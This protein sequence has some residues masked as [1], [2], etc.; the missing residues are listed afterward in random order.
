LS[1]RSGAADLAECYG[2]VLHAATGG[3]QLINGV[4]LG[5]IEPR[6]TTLEAIEASLF[7]QDLAG[8][9]ADPPSESRDQFMDEELYRRA[10]G[11]PRPRFAQDVDLV[12][13]VAEAPAPV[14]GARVESLRAWVGQEPNL[15]GVAAQVARDGDSLRRFRWVVTVLQGAD[16]SREEASTLERF[17]DAL[18]DRHRARELAIPK[19]WRHPYPDSVW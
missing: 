5:S 1:Y 14:K 2:D 9:D 7:E 18:I 15:L 16:L 6:P 17:V 3:T 13:L 4:Q 10:Y 12:Y 11:R 8:L 19:A